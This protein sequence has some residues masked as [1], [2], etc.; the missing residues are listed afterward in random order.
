[1][2]V[3]V[4]FQRTLDLESISFEEGIRAAVDAESESMSAVR[5]R[6]ILPDGYA[7]GRTAERNGCGDWFEL[8]GAR[9]LAISES[10]T[11][12]SHRN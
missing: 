10:S 2:K 11:T 4:T 1:M 9:K 8:L 3:R 7:L 6:E 5:V 12:S